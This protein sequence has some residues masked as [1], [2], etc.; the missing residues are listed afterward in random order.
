MSEAVATLTLNPAVD[1]SMDVEH[2][3]PDDKLR[4]DQP[5]REPGGGGI[6][7]AQ[8]LMRLGAA[9]T[10]VVPRGGHT[11]ALL[12]DLLADRDLDVRPVPIAGA[13][14][15]NTTVTETATGRQYRFV[16]PGPELTADE[17]RACFDALASLDARWM[18]LSG[19]LP[20]AADPQVVT[21]LARRCHQEQRRLLVDTS[22]EALRAAG[23]AGVFV[24]KPN[25]RELRQLLGAGDVGDEDLERAAVDLQRRGACELLLL[26]LG[27]AGGFLVSPEHPDGVR[28]P[29]P[30]VRIRSKVGAGDSSVAGL[31]SA[32]AAGES[33]LEAARWSMA[34]GAAATMTPGSGLARAE[35]VRQLLRG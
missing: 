13:T 3:T 6:N 33:H 29:A 2:V 23:D 11:G 27:A 19:S 32:L 7:V 8:V 24:L 20:P 30:T 25:A 17:I 10:A 4:T 12:A 18:V 21:E 35:D 9:A 14:R 16:L 28:V 1:V 34:A 15:E 22:G 26:T 5:S 31:V